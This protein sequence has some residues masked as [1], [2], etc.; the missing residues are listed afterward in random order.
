M[1]YPPPPPSPPPWDPQPAGQPA[2]GY[3]Y[4]PPGGGPAAA[5]A[6]VKAPALTMMILTGIGMLVG[7]AGLLMNILSVGFAATSRP[8]GSNGAYPMFNGGVG[9]AGNLLGLGVGAF[10][11][12]GLNEM[13]NARNWGVSL[14]AVIVSMAPCLGPCFCINLFV[15]IWAII[16]LVDKDVKPGFTG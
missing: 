5:L 4:G 9:I 6:K 15:G 13:R 8:S 16:V 12:W 1:S 10:A 7:I 2:Y 11:L 14:A 3:G